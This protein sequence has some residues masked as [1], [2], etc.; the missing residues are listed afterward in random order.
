V[1][2]A[3]TGDV[4]CCPPGQRGCPSAP[5]GGRWRLLTDFSDEFPVCTRPWS[6]CAL[7]AMV[8]LNTT[9]WNT[10]VASWGDWTWDPANAKVVTQLPAPDA[11][12]DSSSATA[13]T[14]VGDIPPHS[15]YAALTMSYEEHQR[16]GQTRY[17][18]AGIMKSAL[19]AGVT[20]GR[21]EARIKGASRWPGVCAPRALPPPPSG[22]LRRV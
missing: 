14:A 20:Y 6:K 12:A 5:V 2:F 9:K 19:P 1:S 13:A 15:G 3:K 18:K 11:V 16:G 17:Y 4:T 22:P 8:P 10:S 7:P 21:F